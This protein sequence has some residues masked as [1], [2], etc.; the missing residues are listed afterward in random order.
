MLAT[1]FSAITHVLV[2]ESAHCCPQHGVLH[3][4]RASYCLLQTENA[5]NRLKELLSS[6]PDAIGIKLGIKTSEFE[7]QILHF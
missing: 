2:P 5:A 1:L 3:S 6:K 4:S 7:K